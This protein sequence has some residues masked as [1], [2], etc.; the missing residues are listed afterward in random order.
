MA[1]VL[2]P[3]LGRFP[4]GKNGERNGLQAIVLKPTFKQLS[5]SD[6]VPHDGEDSE[7]YQVRLLNLQVNH[8]CWNEWVISQKVSDMAVAHTALRNALTG[9]FLLVFLG[10]VIAVVHLR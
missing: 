8:L 2:N 5:P 1:T 3:M 4:M 10:L 9:V 6:I 7:A